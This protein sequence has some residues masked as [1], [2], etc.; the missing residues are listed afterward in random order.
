MV[1]RRNEW[2][3]ARM[4]AR[5]N[6]WMNETEHRVRMGMAAAEEVEQE[7]ETAHCNTCFILI[8]YYQATR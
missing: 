5:M 7:E 6:E 4:H 1:I 2:K 8:S 3:N